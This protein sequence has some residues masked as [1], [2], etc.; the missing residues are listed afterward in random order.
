MSLLLNH[1][2]RMTR[3][4]I[5]PVDRSTIVSIY[6]REI[7]VKKITINPSEYVIPAGS[8]SSPGVLEVE[9][10]SWWRDFDPDQPLIEIPE[11]S[12][13]IANS[14]V[15]DYVNGIFQVG[16]ESRLG[17]FVLP[18]KVSAVEV[19]AKHK[20]ALDKAD[21]QQKNWYRRLVEVADIGWART[22]GNPL[23]ISE[24]MRLAAEELGQQPAWMHNAAMASMIRCIA[25][26]SLRNPEFPICG[27][28]KTVVD[29]ALATKLGL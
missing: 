14:I 7:F 16:G 1:H 5:N 6:P 19:K 3:A 12:M 8:Y 9:P 24:D 21:L 2:R 10:A 15:N 29:K 22:N 18:G 25:C 28:C 20:A 23:S 26:G 27:S 13:I 17:I 4:P 11:N